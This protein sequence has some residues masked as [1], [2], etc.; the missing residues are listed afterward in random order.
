MERLNS[1]RSPSDGVEQQQCAAAAAAA[2]AAPVRRAGAHAHLAD[3]SVL[4]A[5]KTAV[6]E[7][8]RTRSVL[9]TLGD[10]PDHE[11]VDIAG[12]AWPRS[13]TRLYRRTWGDS[14]RSQRPSGVDVVSW[15]TTLGDRERECKA[16][17]E[18]VKTPV[19]AVIELEE[20]H[21]AY[22]GLLR[23]A[24]EKLM[25]IYDAPRP[26]SARGYD[27]LPH[28]EATRRW[29]WRNQEANEEAIAILTQASAQAV[30]RV[31]LAGRRLRFLPEAFG[32]T[33]GL[34][35]LDLS[36]N[37]LQAIP[38]SIAGL[39][40]LEE[41]R[42]SSNLLLSL[43]D[44]IGLLQNLKVLNVS[45]NK[46]KALPDSISK[47]RSLVELDAS[48][49]ELAFLPTNMGYELGN[50]QKLCVQLNKLR[51]LPTSVCEMKSLRHLD[52]HFNEL[53]GLPYAIGKL[54]SLESLNVSS[55]F[56]DLKEL[57]PTFGDLTN[58]RELDLSNNQIHVLPDAFAR[59]D[60]LTK[61]NLEQNPLS[62]PP[63][64][65]ASQGVDA[66]KEYMVKRWLDIL[67]EEQQKNQLQDESPTKAGW[68]TRS[69]S[70][71]GTLVSNVSGYLGAGDKSP[72]DPA[73]DQ[74]L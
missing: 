57:P 30:D 12:L 43:P 26:L 3:P 29:W 5:M 47:C 46:L 13:T 1:S 17:A 64:E 25:R 74:D 63:M 28:E 72:R 20:M 67:L 58:L 8:A 69:T 11:A 34:V 9:Q 56:S 37:L 44:S 73:L 32:R 19:R 51:S 70:M 59:L 45:G 16:K 42:V 53:R 6:S 68:L 71:L 24:E 7:V 62:V 22:R 27:L 10:R 23:E 21:E 39:E 2:A 15:R 41:L 4:A 61:L 31:G 14:N 40:H 60:K 66:V 18:K 48:Y 38:D 55:N 33:K 36:D 54:S 35:S 52:A 49:N 50:L 65:V